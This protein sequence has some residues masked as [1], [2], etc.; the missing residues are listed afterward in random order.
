MTLEQITRINELCATEIMG[1]ILS[2]GEAWREG[3]EVRESHDQW[4]DEQT[5]MYTYTVDDNWIESGWSPYT[6]IAQAMEVAD[7][8]GCKWE[9]S[10]Y[11]T[12]RSPYTACVE[13][14][15]NQWFGADTAAAALT[16]ACLRAKGV[17][18]LATT[19]PSPPS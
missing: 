19:A 9:L 12:P 15:P 7:K 5:Q 8:L 3:D 2:K 16:F 18:I 6:N 17:E 11:P 14:S 1:W 13:M 10:Y 4:F